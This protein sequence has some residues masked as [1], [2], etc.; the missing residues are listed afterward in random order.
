VIVAGIITTAVYFYF[1][2]NDATQ[3]AASEEKTEESAQ[4]AIPSEQPVAPVV[5]S[6]DEAV[7]DTKTSTG[8]KSEPVP[9]PKLDVY[10]PAKEAADEE[11]VLRESEHIETI[12]KAFVTSSIEVEIDATNKKSNFHY[13]FMDNKL[14][15]YGA[16]EKNLY[17][18]L[19]FIGEDKRTVFL[20]YKSNYYLLDLTK[21]EP[22]QL[23]PI[24]NPELLKKLKEYRGG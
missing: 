6:T 3:P 23:I 2:S 20:Y 17:E 7:K 13:L 19:E 8:E 4:N 24:K 9:Q 21:T 14:V 15:L 12:S 1:N 11:Q 16:F 22:T 10:D 18:I 5:E